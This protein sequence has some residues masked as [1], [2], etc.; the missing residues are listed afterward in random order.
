VSEYPHLTEA[1]F[2]KGYVRQ[3]GPFSARI[4]YALIRV[5]GPDD[6]LEYVVVP[7]ERDFGGA[8]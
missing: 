8:V 4:A 2:R 7:P 3:F 5:V 6:S 1:E